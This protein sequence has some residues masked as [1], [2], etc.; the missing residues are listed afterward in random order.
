MV[1][2]LKTFISKVRLRLRFGFSKASTLELQKTQHQLEL[3]TSSLPALISCVD[4]E[5]YYRFV[6]LPYE[7]WFG[8]P[9]KDLIGKHVSEVLGLEAFEEVKEQLALA[10]TGKPVTFEKRI[11]YRFGGTRD[12]IVHY[13]PDT[14]EQNQIV[15]IVAI[16]TDI[17]E[18]KKQEEEGSK[19]ASNERIAREASRLKSEFL[20]NM[21]HEIRTPINGVMGM[22]GLL[23]DTPLDKEQREFVETI[24]KSAEGLL[25]IINSILD[26]SKV[27]TG[28]IELENIDF[29]LDE[30]LERTLK[31]L[32][33]SAVQKG[34]KLFIELP[35][36][37]PSHL[38]GDPGK[39]KQILNNLISNALKFTEIGQVVVHCE[40][41]TI[42]NTELVLRFLVKDTG[43]G[44]SKETIQKLFQPFSQADASTTRKFGGTGLGLSITKH[45][46]E[47]MGGSVGVESELDKGSTF[48][49]SLPFKLGLKTL[50]VSSDSYHQTTTPFEAATSA[51]ILLAEDNLINQKIVTKMLQKLNYRVDA[52]DNGKQALDALREIPYDLILM[53]CQMPEIDGYETSRRIRLQKDLAYSSIPIIAITAN[54]MKGDKEKC[55]DAGMNDYIIKPVK[56]EILSAVILKWLPLE[57]QSSPV[58]T[59]SH[60]PTSHVT[61]GQVKSRLNYE[62][63]NDLALIEK[64]GCAPNFVQQLIRLYLTSAP[65][66]LEKLKISLEKK[67]IES[68]II[69]IHTL[70]SSSA[71]LGIQRIRDLCIQFEET[72]PS[73]DYLAFLS[74]LKAIE[75]EYIPTELELKAVLEQQ[76]PMNKEQN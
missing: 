71:N 60:A 58:T 72:I 67:D 27:E 54:A 44:I 66:H 24:N 63:F 19:L 74:L 75:Q 68:I 7:K 52:V 62:V 13:I 3:I 53:D 73:L 38:N 35:P 48:W 10:L 6:N 17:T 22:A 4:S 14:N 40:K 69:E 36:T 28:K 8:I 57:F 5:L 41:S 65:L 76:V 45:L 21:S 31:P 39:L 51:R 30:L 42:N 23:L 64:Q 70:K 12:V 18:R 32:Q 34:I 46:V 9:R 43:I 59:P 61:N 2:L 25:T 56:A 29:N 37:I 49:F 47:Q 11:P 50:N 20:A 55:L 26:F 15:G 33:L 1:S 16:V